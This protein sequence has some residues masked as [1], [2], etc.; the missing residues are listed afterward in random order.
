MSAQIIPAVFAVTAQM[1]PISGVVNTLSAYIDITGQQLVDWWNSGSPVAK[2]II[3]APGAG[4]IIV[5]LSYVFDWKTGVA[6]LDTHSATVTFVWS[7]GGQSTST[8]IGVVEGASK[9][10]NGSLGVFLEARANF[11]NGKFQMA[12]LS[13]GI[14]ATGTPDGT[15]RVTVNYMVLAL[16]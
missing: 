14:T 13:A 16:V 4:K 7:T 2:D 12:D 9:I 11:E 15:L 8:E 6:T 5:P 1:V 3:A 10:E